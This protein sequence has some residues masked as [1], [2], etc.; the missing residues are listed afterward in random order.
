MLKGFVVVFLSVLVVLV[1]PALAQNQ[2]QQ[3][4]T[5]ENELMGISIQHPND[6]EPIEDSNS[7]SF[8]LY[9]NGTKPLVFASVVANPKVMFLGMNSSEAIMKAAIYMV[10]GEDI[11]E[12]YEINNE[13]TIN[14]T[15]NGIPQYTIARAGKYS[16]RI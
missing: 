16:L 6:W 13:T 15:I 11:S 2:T 10:I 5:Y 7:V 3:W 4:G 9:E 1:A 14:G 8:E 12:T